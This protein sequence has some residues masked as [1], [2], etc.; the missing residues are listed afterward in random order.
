VIAADA[1]GVAPW[2][3]YHHAYSL[4]N[5]VHRD[6]SLHGEDL[7][8]WRNLDMAC[9][10]SGMAD[11]VGFIMLHVQ[12]NHHT[13]ALL[14]AFQDVLRDARNAAT[15]ENPGGPWQR[16][17]RALEHINRARREMWS[18]SRPERYNDFRVFIMG[19]TGNEALFGPGVVYEGVEKF[20]GKP[21]QFRGQ[22]GA[23]DDIVPAC[24]IL[25]GIDDAYPANDLTDYLRD[26]RQ[27]RPPVVQRWFEDVRTDREASGLD[28]FVSAEAGIALIAAACVE[29]ITLFRIGH[30]QFVQRYI[31]AHTRH[32]TATGGTPITSW[33]PNQIDAC[34]ARMGQLLD[35]ADPARLS[36][37]ERLW[38]ANMRQRLAERQR[39][40][41]EQRALLEDPAFDPREVYARNAGHE[42][43]LAV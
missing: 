14:G 24:D 16:L 43:A 37:T 9:R 23:Q 36:R 3:D 28:A 20:G 27:Y 21:M 26:L 17:L 34:F 8:H 41:A 10:F 38:H 15:T 30:W 18:A 7:W 11:E 25:L 4:G 39:I 6:S 31:L 35:C 40:L 22:T 13:A 32:A 33:L 2:L 29:Q 42:D 19:I 5:F 1:L 12:I